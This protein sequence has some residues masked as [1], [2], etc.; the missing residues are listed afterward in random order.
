M[1]RGDEFTFR[2]AE[3]CEDVTSQRGGASLFIEVP[4][5]PDA[6]PQNVPV[7]DVHHYPLPIQWVLE[8]RA[9]ERGT[10]S[11]SREVRRDQMTHMYPLG[12]LLVMYLPL[13][14]WWSGLA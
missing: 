2:V 7:V 13:V 6:R 4:T 1:E 3:S 8:Y 9:G 14:T 10:G 12:S 5:F 11:E